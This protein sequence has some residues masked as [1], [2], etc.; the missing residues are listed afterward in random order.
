MMIDEGDLY[1]TSLL[2]EPGWLRGIADD[3][4]SQVIAFVPDTRIVLLYALPGAAGADAVYAAVEKKYR[5]SARQLSPVGYV[6]GPAGT[7]IPYRPEPGDPAHIAAR[8]AE[9]VLAEH[10]R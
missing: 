8:R 3:A 4:S 5:E 9:T 7:V 1:Y 6:A 10:N 2:L